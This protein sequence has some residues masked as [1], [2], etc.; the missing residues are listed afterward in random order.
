[1][2]KIILTVL[3]AFA[4]VCASAQQFNFNPEDMAKRQA[5]QLKETCALSQEQY[6][7][8]LKLY[9]DSS[10]QMQAERDS[11]QKAGGQPQMNMEAFRARQEKQNAEIK[12]ILT[13]EQY[14]KYEEAMKQR[15]Q[16]FGGQGGGH[17]P[18]RQQ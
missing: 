6:D 14:A 11:L 3:V 4:T 8:V 10:K 5:E 13:E 16:R 12:K 7:K 2:K 1:M 18:R 17:R 15:R 9:L